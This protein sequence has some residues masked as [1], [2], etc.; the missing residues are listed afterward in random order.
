MTLT[1]GWDYTNYW[2][3]QVVDGVFYEP[4]PTPAPA[5]LLLFACGLAVLI[6]YRRKPAI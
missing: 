6:I 2:D 5:T 1:D 4:A 3:W